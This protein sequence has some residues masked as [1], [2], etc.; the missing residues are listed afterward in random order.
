VKLRVTTVF[1]VL[2]IFIF[3]GQNTP[4]WNKNCT[5]QD[6]TSGTLTE[7]PSFTITA[8][9]IERCCSHK[10]SKLLYGVV[11]AQRTLPAR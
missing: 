4:R 5:P 1:K 8:A 10:T 2:A 7:A 11:L 9:D 3:W 6:L